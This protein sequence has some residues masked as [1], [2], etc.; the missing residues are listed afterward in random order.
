MKWCDHDMSSNL[1]V[2]PPALFFQEGVCRFVIGH[3]E[4][5]FQNV[6][7]FSSLPIVPGHDTHRFGS[8]L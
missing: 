2:F 8:G 1:H 6:F 4:K 3:L 5:C 7:N